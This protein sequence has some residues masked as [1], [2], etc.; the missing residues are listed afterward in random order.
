MNVF[1]IPLNMA[2]FHALCKPAL[3]Q[4]AIWQNGDATR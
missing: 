1:V 3:W 4:Q 2:N